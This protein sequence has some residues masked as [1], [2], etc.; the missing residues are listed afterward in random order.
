M[1]PLLHLY[2]SQFWLDS[3]SPV[4]V[5]FL[6]RAVSLSI[7]SDGFSDGATTVGKDLSP[8]DLEPPGLADSIIYFKRFFSL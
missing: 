1:V 6:L 4:K 8:A 3:R 7:S 2:H 5:T